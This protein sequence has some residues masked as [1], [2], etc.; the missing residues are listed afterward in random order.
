MSSHVTSSPDECTWEELAELLGVPLRAVDRWREDPALA[1]KVDR[2][3]DCITQR[4]AMK[5]LA[6][7]LNSD[8][9][10]VTLEAIREV[11]ATVQIVWTEDEEAA[12]EERWPP[13]EPGRIEGRAQHRL[14]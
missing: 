1:A 2:L 11:L 13:S 4:R 5:R 8:D 3:R 12:Q 6:R 10:W 9:P 7:L 14:S